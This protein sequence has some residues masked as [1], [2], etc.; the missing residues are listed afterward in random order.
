MIPLQVCKV[1]EEERKQEVSTELNKQKV[2]GRWG[3]C[4]LGQPRSAPCTELHPAA[5]SP[6]GKVNTLLP[7]FLAT[8]LRSD[9][10]PFPSELIFSICTRGGKSLRR[11]LSQVTKA[12]EKT[13]SSPLRSLQDRC[14]GSTAPAVSKLFLPGCTGHYSCSYKA[15]INPQAA[16]YRGKTPRLVRF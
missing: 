4:K 10:S 8:D 1:K 3:L 7:S 2:P 16:S 5:L 14:P 11:Y 9:R 13:S 15:H 6:G 12:N